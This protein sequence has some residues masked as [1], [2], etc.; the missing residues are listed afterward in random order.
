VTR[1]VLFAEVPQFYA[2]VERCEDPSLRDRPVVVGGDPRKRGLVQAATLDALA[3][4]VTLEMTMLEALRVCPRAR[5][6]RTDMKRYRE[7]SGRLL[8][9]LRQGFDRLESFGLGAAYFDVSGS[10]EPPASI[11]E[12][13]VELVAAAPGLPLRVG[14]ASSKSLA[15]LAAEE[16]GEGGVRRVQPGG[17]RAFLDPLP[18][19]RL[20]GVGQKTAARLAELG[21]RTIADVVA[22]G[23]ARLEE[24]FGTHGLRIHALASGEDD[25]PV[26]AARHPQSLSREA[27]LRAER[28]DL[29]VLEETLQRLAQELEAELTLQALGAGRITLK[30]RYADQGTTTRS[31]TLATPIGAAAEIQGV[32]A[33]LLSRVQTGSRPVRGVG[34]Q[35]G[36][37]TPA[38]ERDRQLELFRSSR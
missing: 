17:E 30:L 13:L 4:G 25:G 19:A 34:I 22:L 36:R 21:A 20:E 31:Q 7:V 33:R 35:L 28:L 26:R 32:S 27:T 1:V 8:A 18:A 9:R 15:R 2:T 11:A 37:L 23:R 10:A 38:V 3:E 16:A 14:M 24:V 6:V 29:S 5:A 12:R